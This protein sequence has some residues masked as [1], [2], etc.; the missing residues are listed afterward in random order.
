AARDPGAVVYDALQAALARKTDVVLIDT[1]GR[2]HTQKNLM[3]ELKK[4]RR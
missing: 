3:E 1:A 4:I 2:I